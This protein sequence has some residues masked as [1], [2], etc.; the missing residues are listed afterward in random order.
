MSLL[1]NYAGRVMQ[2]VYEDLSELE[3]KITNE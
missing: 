3:D 1:Q 2:F